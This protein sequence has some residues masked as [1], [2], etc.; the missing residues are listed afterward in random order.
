M[1]LFI[2]RPEVTPENYPAVFEYYDQRGPNPMFAKLGHLAM[3]T[4]FKPFVTMKPENEAILN[5][6]LTS[7]TRMMVVSN[8]TKSETDQY[9]LASSVRQIPAINART[10]FISIMGKMSLF[11]LPGIWGTAKRYAIDGLGGIPVARA[12]DV[13]PTDYP[14]IDELRDA[15][16]E[17]R[18]NSVL[19]R[20]LGI[21]KVVRDELDIAGFAEGERLKEGQDPRVVRKLKTGFSQIHAELVPATKVVVVTVGLFNGDENIGYDTKR[22]DMVFG[23]PLITDTRDQTEFNELLKSNMQRD[24]TAAVEQRIQRSSIPN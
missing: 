20:Q 21:N 11:N 1:S 18:R 23:K 9:N 4:V 15:I 22:P 2:S 13:D 17:Q 19:S 7:S 8:H 14:N 6:E 16:E 3:S 5:S 24:L 10:G 12:K